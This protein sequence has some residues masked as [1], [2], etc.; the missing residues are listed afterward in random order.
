LTD[1]T[2]ACN[3]LRALNRNAMAKILLLLNFFSLV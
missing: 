3:W 2:V 1:F